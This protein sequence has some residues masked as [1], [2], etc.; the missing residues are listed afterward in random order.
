[1]PTQPNLQ[2][3]DLINAVEQSPLDAKLWHRLALE[4]LSAGRPAEAAPAASNAVNLAPLVAEYHFA[5]ARTL[6]SIGDYAA[7][8]AQYEFALRLT[9]GNPQLLNSLAAAC[10]RVGLLRAA[11]QLYRR[12]L[13]AAPTDAA[14]QQGLAATRVPR[15]T[16]PGEA[17]RGPVLKLIREAEALLTEGRRMEALQAYAECARLVPE[18]PRVHYWTGCVLH[19]LARLEAALACYD[20]ASRIDPTFCEAAMAAVKISASLGLKDR[21]TRHLIHAQRLRTDPG[22]SIQ[23]SL[24]TDAI[25][26]SVARIDAAR[27]QFSSGID[28]LPE[29][30][31]CNRDLHVK[32]SGA[33]RSAIPDLDWTSP[34]CRAPRPG[35]GRIKIGFISQFLYSHSIGKTTRGFIAELSR[36]RFEVFVVHIPPILSDETTSWMK[37]RADHWITLPDNLTQAREQLASLGLDILFYQDIGLEPFSYC[38]AHARLARV[39]CVS[40][41]H[42][43]TTGIPNMDYF[44]SSDLYETAESAAHYSER[45]VQL[46]DLPSLAYYYRPERKVPNRTR[47]QFGLKDNEHVY[48]CPQTLFKLHP[49]FD[50]LIAGILERDGRGRLL[51][52]S[53]HGSEWSMRLAQRFSA[54][55]PHVS[56]R[57]QFVPALDLDG[58][59]QL[60]SVVDVVLDTI[61]FNGMNTSLEAFSVGTPVV[62]LPGSMQRGRHTQAMYRRMGIE[63]CVAADEESYIAIAVGLAADPERR[64]ALRERIL[65]RNEVLFEDAR[66]IS[67]FEGFFERAHEAGGQ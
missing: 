47:A 57:I 56:D 17:V 14:A 22:L 35:K 33:L 8:I 64:G 65:R 31:L 16:E 60:L 24:L 45:L 38:L 51:L 61:H 28:R 29:Y 3:S 11:A 66:V 18:S 26:D 32:L 53:A 40:F 4:M 21:A 9:P 20:L 15:P 34:H 27:R 12:V 23:L 52:I 25:H 1:M 49:D 7:A 10:G 54:R 6:A 50:R 39:Q 5:F 36:E 46:H 58:F 2:L 30:G 42:P 43:D 44:V 63:D 37:A 19:D 62:T 13:A 48:L 55:I 67:E 41:G 59:L